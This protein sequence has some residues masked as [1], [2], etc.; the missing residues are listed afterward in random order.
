MAAG[1]VSMK[2]R[3][4]ILSGQIYEG[5]PIDEVDVSR[6]CKLNATFLNAMP[7]QDSAIQE[8]L[9]DGSV[10]TITNN[11]MA[12]SMTLPAVR[13]TGLVGTG[14][15]IAC[16]HLII[17]S[18]DAEGSTFTVQQIID[19]KKITTIFYGVSFKNVPHLIV[20]GNAVIEYPVVMNYAGWVQSVNSNS[21]SA[22]SI[23]AVGNKYG[24]KG[25]YKPYEIQRAENENDPAE[26][27]SGRPI[28][29]EVGGV[30]QGSGDSSEGDIDKNVAV[31]PNPLATQQA[32]G[33]VEE[34]APPPGW[35]T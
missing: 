9:V 19:G 15:F 13:T 16:A 14:D 7:A 28:T 11:S 24:L 35:D 32:G 2:L 29:D 8:V 25:I 21:A 17:A 4:P 27:F 18:K 34:V 20:A 6:S 12:G 10:I 30:I 31:V 22:K 3:H 23:W 5:S 33:M 1:G 26:F